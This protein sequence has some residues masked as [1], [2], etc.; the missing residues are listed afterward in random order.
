M[1]ILGYSSSYFLPEYWSNTPLYGEKIIPLIDYILS[2]DYTESDKLANAFYNLENKYKNTGNLP[3]DQIEAI[4]EESGYGYVRDLLANDEESLR[5]LVYL[6]VLIHELKGSSEGIQIVLNLLKSGGKETV[7]VVI[8]EPTISRSNEV[9]D[10]TTDDY[11]TYRNFTTDD[12]P[13]ELK[14]QIRTSQSFT[15]EQ[16][17]ASIEDHGLYLGINTE[18]KL[19]LSVGNDKT[20]WN[21]INNAQSSGR[22]LPNSV[23]YLRL[24]FDGNEYVLQVSE[25]DKKYDY[26][27]SVQSK[28]PL[29]AHSATI[30]VGVD[31]SEGHPSKP[32]LGYIFLGPLSFNVENITIE[33]WF[34]QDPIGEEDTFLVKADLDI[35]LLSS[36]F[37][38]KFAEFAKK[39]VYP[40]LAAFEAKVS[41][42]NNTTFLPYVRQ[43]VLYIGRADLAEYSQ[44]MVISPSSYPWVDN[45]TV[46]D[47][48]FALSNDGGTYDA[49]QSLEDSA[50]PP[51][52]IEYIYGTN[53]ILIRAKSE[54]QFE[55]DQVVLT[56]SPWTSAVAVSAPDLESLKKDSLLQNTFYGRS[57]ISSVSLPK[58]T[59][60]EGANTLNSTF[61]GCNN[62]TNLDMSKLEKV[63]G[64]YNM[65]ETFSGCG[66]LTRANL[67]SLKTVTGDRCMYHT[68]N[69]C[70][71][72][73][74]IELP[75]LTSVDGNYCFQSTFQ[76]CSGSVSTPLNIQ[77][78]KLSTVTGTNAMDSAFRASRIGSANFPN[79]IT[80]GNSGLS[81]IFRNCSALE[82]V[83]IPR[84]QYI[85]S[86][87]LDSAFVGCSQL[88]N[89][90][91]SS[92][93]E[94]AGF[95]MQESFGSCTH[96]VHISLPSL[97]TVNGQRALYNT[98]K[99]CSQLQDVGFPSLSSITGN[100]AF[101]NTFSNCGALKSITFPEL[102]SA[103]GDSIFSG[104][105]QACS[106]LESVSFPKL[107]DL[108]TN[109]STVIFENSFSNCT[110][111]KTLDLSGLSILESVKLFDEQTFNRCSQLNSVDLSNLSRIRR[112]DSAL[113]GAFKDRTSL[114]AV[115][116]S[117]L[118]TI[119]GN[120][121]MKETFSGCAGVTSFPCP[122]LTYIYS[123]RTM[124][125]TFSG[126]VGI[127][128]VDL[129][130]LDTISGDYVMNG[131]F[132]GC[133]GITSID[134]SNLRDVDGTSCF[135]N[136]TFESCL[137]VSSVT[138]S[139]L[140]SVSGSH[141]MYRTFVP[142]NTASFSVDLSMLS[143][144]TG[145]SAMEGTFKGCT[146]LNSDAANLGFLS[147]LSLG[148]GVM[149]ETF[150]GCTSITSFKA[151]LTSI[152]AE[153]AL[154]EVCFGCTSLTSIVLAVLST[155][156]GQYALS[157][158]FEGC[159]SLTSVS[160]PKLSTIS[161]PFAFSRTFANCTSLTELSFPKLNSAS[162]GNIPTQFGNMLYGVTGCTIH[163]P[164]NLQPTISA[165]YGYPNFGGTN[166]T[167]LFDLPA[168]S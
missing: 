129:S 36:D 163:F 108:V 96:L 5:L 71:R 8:G 145:D 161:G 33:E 15:S 64:S 146:G 21:I 142:I 124:E 65:A 133:R 91:L 95:G 44:F 85:D 99:Y 47:D 40:S 158:A 112:G 31:V 150:S 74:S 3:I 19:V 12:Q 39:Y 165:L 4:I 69:D 66:K 122:N 127:T 26:A 144:V 87:A 32:Y 141:A 56:D 1:S 38:R 70:S 110:K 117:S 78:P 120:A 116:L 98:F 160:F 125:S 29:L 139:S 109:T 118:D 57:A 11:L 59:V 23:Y 131:T 81:N 134:L 52:I 121:A 148:S 90:D 18:G 50:H 128:S 162:F 86:N 13:F 136:N 100:N 143:R 43:K 55:E 126:C 17:I 20:S 130:K 79:L 155:I 140:S 53:T 45:N 135:D 72:L 27:I 68:F 80:V 132:R 107:A 76:N 48:F 51:Y 92:V 113:M 115:D 168:T 149:K 46:W 102:M 82:S 63:S 2:A 73:E 167:V 89:V 10:F 111:L 14:F 84:L 94:I 60:S 119:S 35:N 164:S 37:F 104:T 41:F 30:Y 28:Q 93:T 159:T 156:S 67:P 157:S 25:D 123:D 16:C 138:L 7:L 137:N 151:P 101:K 114:T 75:E 152:A 54:F 61:S 9:S 154:E 97:S 6:L 42:E 88:S 83:S 49:F 153:R 58:L 147:S 105:F 24:S 62:L 106:N 77:F 22:L 34:E 166:T 103:T